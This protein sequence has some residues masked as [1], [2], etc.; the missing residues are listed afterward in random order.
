LFC[1]LL[2]HVDDFGRCEACPALLRGKLF[3][4]KLDTVSEADVKRWV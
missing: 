1:R 3:A 2:V 4:R